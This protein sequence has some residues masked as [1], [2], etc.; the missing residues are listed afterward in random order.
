MNEFKR[1]EIIS[2]YEQALKYFNE[3]VQPK[4]TD[5]EYTSNKD[6]FDNKLIRLAIHPNLELNDEQKER[7]I[8][9]FPGHCNITGISQIS[10]TFD[11]KAQGYGI[12]LF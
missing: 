1:D 10:Y 5:E 8:K 6:F 12:S 3:R 11:F 9:F 4:V 2:F 7:T